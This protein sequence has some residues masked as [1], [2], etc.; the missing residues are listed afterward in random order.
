[1]TESR[2]CT[3]WTVRDSF[4]LYG[5]SRW[6][7]GFFGINE[8]GNVEVCLRDDGSSID[9]LELVQDLERR[10]LRTPLLIRFSDI[11][12]GR[13]EQLC[14]AFAKSI[15]T[16][17]Y[18]GS[19]RGVYPIKVNQSRQVVKEIIQRIL[20]RTYQNQGIWSILGYGSRQQRATRSPDSVER[21]FSPFA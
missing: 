21:D 12:A 13:I 19:F 18:G 16:Y 11:L 6:G 10:D 7:A 15:E 14:G 3:D 17:G 5:A 9:L 4:E 2:A 1:M 8:K 20:I